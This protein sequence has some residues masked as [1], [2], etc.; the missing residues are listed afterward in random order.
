L[1]EGAGHPEGPMRLNRFLASCGVA[2]RRKADDLVRA[3]RVSL[4]GI[5]VT[6]VGVPVPPGAE[7]RL[8]GRLLRRSEEVY[9]AMNK[10]RGVLSAVTDR[11]CRTVTDLL[12][13]PLRRLRV[14]PVG[15]LDRDSEGL[16]LLTNDGDF[17]R[18]VSHPSSGIRKRYEVWF[19]RPPSRGDAEHLAE[20]ALLDGRLVRPLSVRLL[21]ER[22]AF[23]EIVLAEG[24]NREIRRLASAVGLT[25]TRLFRRAIGSLVLRDLPAGSFRSFS[26]E[27]LFRLIDAGVIV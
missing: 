11:R 20:G 21:E 23:L 19:D 7:I 13:P 27:R 16:L 25:V 24:I 3:G 2:S 4:N 10:P 15:R 14:Y 5:L 18:A 6:Q 8:D 9:L 1:S 17:C 12:P 26:R 22:G